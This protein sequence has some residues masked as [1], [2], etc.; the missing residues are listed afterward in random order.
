MKPLKRKPGKWN[1]S[2]SDLIFRSLFLIDVKGGFKRLLADDL[3]FN[4][5]ILL[6]V[7]II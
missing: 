3:E 1:K 7:Y 4:G 2:H 5:N 6:A